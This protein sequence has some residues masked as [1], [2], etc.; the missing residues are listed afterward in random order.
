M[1]KGLAK[2]IVLL[3]F[4]YVVG[5]C[6]STYAKDIKYLGITVSKPTVLS[7]SEDIIDFSI[8]N[9]DYS[10][11]MKGNNLLIV[12]DGVKALPTTLFVRY[13]KDKNVFV[14]EI[15]PDD[16]API[17]QVIEDNTT[18]TGMKGGKSNNSEKEMTLEE[19]KKAQQLTIFSPHEKQEYFNYGIEKNGVKVLVVNIM[20]HQ[21][22]SY[23]RIFVKNNTSIPLNI[24][25]VSFEYI[26]YQRKYIIFRSRK[27]KIVTATIAPESVEIGANQGKYFIFAIPTYTS[28]G[29]LE[30][31]FGESEKGE[32]EFSIAI[33]MKVLLQAKRK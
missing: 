16:N 2:N 13:G 25:N 11:Q 21:E 17:H 33:P 22:N 28:N 4:I 3:C 31:F 9:R 20:H 1:N 26:S 24:G 5:V 18:H 6:S 15:S 30:I 10:I 12:A 14:A 23:F 7:F 27:S 8:G 19:E 29:G 32:R